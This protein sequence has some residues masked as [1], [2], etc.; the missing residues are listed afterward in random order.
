MKKFVEPEILCRKFA[1]ED[2]LTTSS[3]EATEP[4]SSETEVMP[5]IDPDEGI[6][7]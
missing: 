4:E 5:T 7:I 6:I 2:I 3:I 1:V